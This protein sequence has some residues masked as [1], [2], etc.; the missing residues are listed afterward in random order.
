MLHKLNAF[1]SYSLSS[2]SLY[3]TV[4]SVTIVGTRNILSPSFSLCFKFGTDR[5]FISFCA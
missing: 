2:F 1:I 3:W 4:S 5:E